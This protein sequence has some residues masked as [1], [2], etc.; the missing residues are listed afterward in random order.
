MLHCNLCTS[1]ITFL[2]SSTHTKNKHP[3]STDI[4]D[5]SE[6]VYKESGTQQ[7]VQQTQQKIQHLKEDAEE[8]W[9]TS[10]N[11]W[12]YRAS[13]VYDTITAESEFAT[14]T[15][16]LQILDPEFTLES[17]KHNVV[18][19]TLPNIMNLFLMGRINEL[20][21]ILGAIQTTLYIPA[22]KLDT[23]LLGIS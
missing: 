22:T 7:K 3:N 19:Y 2:S 12:I 8:A 16:Q 15:K 5:K 20:K 1:H 23:T 6:Q 11:P 21:P 10:Q 14:A 4:L 9:E 17:W 18:E 13:S